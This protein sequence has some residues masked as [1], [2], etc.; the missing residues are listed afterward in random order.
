[1]PID[2]EQLRMPRA[3]HGVCV[4]ADNVTTFN[5]I[6]R[7]S[8]VFKFQQISGVKMCFIAVV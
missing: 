6:I 2:N 1:M 7:E 5:G 3:C 4:R 8:I